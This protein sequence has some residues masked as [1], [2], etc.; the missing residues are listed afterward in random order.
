ML[1]ALKLDSVSRPAAAR[2]REA[3]LDLQDPGFAGY[4]ACAANFRNLTG[5]T[6]AA[7]A[8]AAP[9]REVPAARAETSRAPATPAPSPEHSVSRGSEARTERAKADDRAEDARPKPQGPEKQEAPKAPAS[10]KEEAKATPPEPAKT[11]AAPAK[12]PSSAPSALTASSLAASSLPTSSLPSSAPAASATTTWAEGALPLIQ[13]AQSQPSA[14]ETRSLKSSALSATET[15]ASVQFGTLKAQS[16]LEQ[17]APGIH[18]RFQPSEGAP[19]GTTSRPALTELLSLPKPDIEIPKPL[20]NVNQPEGAKEKDLPA[21]SSQ[22]SIKTPEVSVT[23]LPAST[24]APSGHEA[25]LAASAKADVLPGKAT[26]TPGTPIAAADSAAAVRG[27]TPVP[28]L[29]SAQGTRANATFA[30]MDGTIRWLLKNQEKGAEIQLNPESLGRVVIKL[31]VEGGEVHARLWASEATTVPILQEQKTA[32]EASLRQQGLTLGSFDLQQ[33]RR[34]DDAPSTSQ[35]SSSGFGAGIAESSRKKQDL[36]IPAPALL[37]G[38]H[39]IEV[40]A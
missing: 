7:P 12:D 23:T 33:G 9:V 36:P 24:M 26:V 30:Q 18:L 16:L 19:A 2:E 28:S 20:R 5:P 35:G 22:V 27:T 37:G 40:F 3:G 14:L 17:A 11:D 6:P 25:L 31:R 21:L 29:E 34:G 32:L 4:L 38:A 10:P 13:A 8:K 39:L 1:Q 15:T